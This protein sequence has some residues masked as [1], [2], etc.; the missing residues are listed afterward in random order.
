MIKELRPI[1]INLVDRDDDF[2]TVKYYYL[3]DLTDERVTLLL[4][5]IEESYYGEDD[6]TLSEEDYLKKYFSCDETAID[7]HTYE[8]PSHLREGMEE[9]YW[10]LHTIIR[11]KDL[12]HWDFKEGKEYTLTV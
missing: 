10:I 8:P 11:V 7:R 12:S 5:M 9:L 6:E 1:K 2:T 3:T 4:E